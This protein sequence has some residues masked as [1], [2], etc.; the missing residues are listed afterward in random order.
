M[1]PKVIIEWLCDHAFV[2]MEHAIK[3]LG[4]LRVDRLINEYANN[5]REVQEI[6]QLNKLTLIS[7]V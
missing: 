6:L 5:S 3:V 4:Q 7:L 2:D 1:D